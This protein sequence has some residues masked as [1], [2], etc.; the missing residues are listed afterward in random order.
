MTLITSFAAPL[1]LR[2]DQHRYLDSDSEPSSS[3][4][5]DV[6]EQPSTFTNDS[7]A[8]QD[9]WMTD[10]TLVED[11]S[12]DY[13]DDVNSVTIGK[14]KGRA[15]ST[16]VLS[17]SQ[18][19]Q[20]HNKTFVPCSTQ[21]HRSII[22]AEGICEITLLGSDSLEEKATHFAMFLDPEFPS[23]KEKTL[24]PLFRPASNY[25]LPSLNYFIDLQDKSVK[26]IPAVIKAVEHRKAVVEDLTTGLKRTRAER[27]RELFEQSCLTCRK[28]GL[29]CI[30][31]VIRDRQLPCAAC[32]R[33]GVSCRWA[34]KEECRGKKRKVPFDMPDDEDLLERESGKSDKRPVK[35]HRAS[36]QA[37]LTEQGKKSRRSPI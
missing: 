9:A 2:H 12:E 7:D 20:L 33:T 8:D 36:P 19:T 1:P 30:G 28:E 31:K 11:T 32:V 13:D 17:Q 3:K 4:A 25:N 34:T 24:K 15:S 16:P 5:R 23:M 26:P 14:G 18:S 10:D 21:L 22:D 27:K 29:H 6:S 37:S 35:K